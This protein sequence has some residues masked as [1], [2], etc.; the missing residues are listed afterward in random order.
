VLQ[1]ARYYDPLL[2]RF[3]SADS[4]VPG[5]ASGSME[6]VALKPLTVDFHEPGFVG[7]LNGENRQPFWFQISDE[8][9]R[10]AGN[11]WRT[12]FVGD[13]LSS[14]KPGCYALKDTSMSRIKTTL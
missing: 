8:Q 12:F 4:I 6:G 10:K 7:R 2:A 9:R 1:N 14:T 11:P 5:S 13:V 3:V